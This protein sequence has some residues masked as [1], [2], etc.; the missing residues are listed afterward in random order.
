MLVPL[1]LAYSGLLGV[2]PV[3]GLY[4]LTLP[5]GAYAI[6]GG[7]RLFVVGPDAAVVVL[8]AATVA[9]VAAVGERLPPRLFAPR[10]RTLPVRASSFGS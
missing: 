3:V 8:A 10:G 9:G 2:D 6:F 4:T 5:L 1:P 7:S